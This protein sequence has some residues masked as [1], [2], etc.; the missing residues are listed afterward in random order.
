MGDSKNN[1]SKMPKKEKKKVIIGI[2]VVVVIIAIVIAFV[3]IGK[4]TSPE[5]PKAITF[6]EK[7]TITEFRLENSVTTTEEYQGFK[8]ELD[9]YSGM[10]KDSA[11]MSVDDKEKFIEF[12]RNI[13]NKY[14]SSKA[15]T[16]AYHGLVKK[17][18]DE[19]LA[20]NIFTDTT[21]AHIEALFIEY[22]SLYKEGKYKEAFGKMESVSNELSVGITEDGVKHERTPQEKAAIEEKKAAEAKAEMLA[23][24]R[25]TAYHTD[26]KYN[27]EV[28]DPNNGNKGRVV[29]NGTE[30]YD[31]G[32]GATYTYISK[33]KFI[34]MMTRNGTSEE[35][36]RQWAD[37]MAN[38]AGLIPIGA[39]EDGTYE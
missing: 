19:D 14:T 6:Q 26:A 16:L 9:G 8:T 20:N 36:A 13:D 18:Y 22:D 4:I 21:K 1:Q 2:I 5:P 25:G 37:M 32:N 23:S 29:E 12:T 11:K 39:E 10:I 24:V 15:R 34:E 30:V 3:V 35:L 33:D 27:E 7:Y 38:G 31:Q 28:S 17:Q